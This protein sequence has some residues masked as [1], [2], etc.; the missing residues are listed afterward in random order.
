MAHAPKGGLPIHNQGELAVLYC[1]VFL[2]MAARGSGPYS[3]DAALH[4]PGR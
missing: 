3:L 1:F 4:K 2:Y